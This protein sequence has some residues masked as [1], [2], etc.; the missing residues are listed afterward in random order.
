MAGTHNNIFKKAD[1]INNS[2]I[3][4]VN[5]RQYTAAG[6]FNA[7][8]AELPRLK[9][10]GVQILW[11]MPITP[12]SKKNRKGELGSYYACSDYVSVNPEFGSL[13]DLKNLLKHA[14]AMGFK[15][16]MDWVA[17]HTGWDHVWTISNPEFYLKD[18]DNGDF[19]RAEG[20]EDIIELDFSNTALRKAMINAMEFWISECDIDGFRCD[21]AFWVQLDFWVEARSALEQ[22]KTLFWLGEFDPLDKPEYCTVFDA[23]YTWTWMHKTETFYKERPGLEFLKDV[24]RRYDAVCNKDHIP[25]WFT[26]NHDENSWN[27]T[28]YEKYGDMTKTLAVFSFTWEGISMIY[29]GQELPNRKRLKFFEKDNIEWAPQCELHEFY[30]TLLTLHTHHPALRAADA[31]VANIF[32]QTNAEAN[33]LAY[34]RK[35][36]NNSVLVLLN[37]SDAAIKCNINTVGVEGDY[38]D[39]FT[40]TTFFINAE[41]TFNLPPWGFLLYEN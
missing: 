1:F 29:S 25:L 24:L 16:M 23:V 15:I 8:L 33:V 35:S 9:D 34:E 12:I 10:M 28:E 14:K 36:R 17:N 41:T 6:T 22:T 30:K 27:G 26:S 37:L 7:F 31:V 5:L 32:L 18:N 11:F 38:T 2:N 20:M 3:Y 40:K 39:V 21:L 4:E 13:D 19:K